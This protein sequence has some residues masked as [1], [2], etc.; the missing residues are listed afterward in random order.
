MPLLT[1]ADI[2][3]KVLYCRVIMKAGRPSLQLATLGRQQWSYWID[4]KEKHQELKR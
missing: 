4:D 3:A 2:Q 1:F